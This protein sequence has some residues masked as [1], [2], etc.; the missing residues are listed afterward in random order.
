MKIRHCKMI[1][2]L[3]LVIFVSLFSVCKHSQDFDLGSKTQN[4]G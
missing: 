1:F 3:I 4:G 2:L